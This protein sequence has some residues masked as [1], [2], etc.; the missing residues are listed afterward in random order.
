MT[1]FGLT[2]GMALLAVAI[3]AALARSVL[4]G[5]PTPRALRELTDT[6]AFAASSFMRIHA[7][8]L[9]VLLLLVGF[10]LFVAFGFAR[11]HHVA[12]PASSALETACWVAGSFALGALMVLASLHIAARACATGAQRLAAA[13]RVPAA[14]W[15]PLALRASAPSG[16]LASSLPLIGL[17]LVAA[18]AWL[19]LGALNEPPAVD[20]SRLPLLV[21]GYGFGASVCAL[22]ARILGG[23]FTSATSLSASLAAEPGSALSADHPKNPAWLARTV[24]TSLQQALSICADAPAS[25][26]AT[27]VASMVL[28][29]G[30]IKA[31]A[32]RIGSPMGVLL[33][34]PLV[35]AFGLFAS[36][37]GVLVVRSDARERAVRAFDRGL[38]TTVV[39][40]L[41]GHVA[42][43]RWVFDTHWLEVSASCAAGLGAGVLGMVVSR[44][45]ANPGAAAQGQLEQAA[46]ASP[47][48]LALAGAAKGAERAVWLS[49]ATVLPLAAAWLATSRSGLVGG[50]FYGVGIATAAMLAPVAFVAAVQGV[51]STS[52][53]ASAVL[54]VQPPSASEGQER[55]HRLAEIAWAGRLGSWGFASSAALG[56]SL[57]V[58]AA[59]GE[60]ARG[61]GKPPGVSPAASSVGAVEVA[62]ALLVAVAAVGW[63]AARGQTAVWRAADPA[64]RD[65]RAHVGTGV[66]Q[67]GA[68]LVFEESYDPEH[69]SCLGMVL[70]D[71]ARQ[72][73][74]VGLLALGMA[75][76]LEVMLQVLTTRGGF[77]YAADVVGMVLLAVSLVGLGLAGALE[78]AGAVLAALR[79]VLAIKFKS[80]VDEGDKRA[81]NPF[82][83][84]AIVSDTVG[85]PLETMAAPSLQALIR[86]LVTVT[87]VLAPLFL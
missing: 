86:V 59:I 3:A 37:V 65:I 69:Q 72:A 32:T 28:G 19:R 9:V 80:A 76:G 82:H 55:I 71:A 83:G 78:G 33:F 84:A 77:G 70:Q 47:G 12:D 34:A 18:A 5:D 53:T 14:H 64:I 60:L 15:I 30:L 11:P 4:H 79:R 17:V 2:L 13:T 22:S 7:R 50:G 29:A 21:L 49:A 35:V 8:A 52:G 27:C 46:A 16:L 66:R 24:A 26:A 10:V 56:V 74:P 58:V 48:T 87:M 36:L 20:P 6:V 85:G 38:G 73:I 57:T 41:A 54:C 62:A 45:L 23:V 51:A 81:N 43:A 31:N 25:I 61:A 63:Y 68:S 67:E 1:E 39:L 44:S 75:L 42:C 40:C